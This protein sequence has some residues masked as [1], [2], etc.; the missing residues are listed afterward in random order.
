MLRKSENIQNSTNL[1][2]GCTIDNTP[3]LSILA[4]AFPT[5]LIGF[6]EHTWLP[7]SSLTVYL[8]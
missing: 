6:G 2:L 1:F 5:L 7:G 8:G 3:T 4:A